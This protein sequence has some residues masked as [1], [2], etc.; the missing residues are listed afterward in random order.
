MRDWPRIKPSGDSALLVEFENR[1]DPEV[2]RSVRALALTIE[3]DRPPGVQEILPAYRTLMVTYDPLQ[4]EYPLLAEK[5]Q[6]WTNKAERIDLPPKRLFRLPA[7]YGG[8]HG[9]DL[10][11]VAKVLDLTPGEVIR[12]FS[13]TRFPV[14][15]IGFICGLAY[16]GGMPEKLRVPRLASP[17]TLVPAGSVGFAGGQ[18]NAI[19]T[20]QPSGFNYIGRTYV[21]LYDPKLFP[22]IPFVAGD[23]VSFPPVSEE[24]ALR[25]KGRGAEDFL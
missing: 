1:I 25:V 3:S 13:Q 12:I 8:A 23:E 6:G 10:E 11:H 2:N 18:A 22:P 20:D 17:R 21:I 7:V 9:P 5:I 16:L 19:A 24:E 4:I 15:F 14:Y